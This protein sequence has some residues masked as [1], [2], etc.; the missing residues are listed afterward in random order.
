MVSPEE[1]LLRLIRGGGSSGTV[2]GEPPSQAMPPIALSAGSLGRAPRRWQWPA[3]SLTAVNLG[4][5]VFVVLEAALLIVLI[6]APQPT[7]LPASAR[8]QA[9]AEPANAH[10]ATAEVT[11]PM[12]FAVSR[13]LFQLGSG[14]TAWSSSPSAGAGAVIARRFNLI[15]V[16]A[17]EPSQAVIEDTQTTKTYFVTRGQPVVEGWMVESVG[18]DRVLLDRSGEKLELSL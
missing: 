17:G 15:G 6:V 9:H 2:A 3:W 4:L 11:A 7:I 16:V 1:R 10:T 18:Q 12:T 13:P 14:E 8:P 5:G